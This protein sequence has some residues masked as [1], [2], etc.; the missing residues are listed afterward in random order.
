VRAAVEAGI[1]SSPSRPIGGDGCGGGIGYRTGDF[2]FYG[3]LPRNRH[4]AR[5]RPGSVLS[6]AGG[7]DL[8][9][10][11]SNACRHA[12]R[13]RGALS[14][15]AARRGPRDDEVHE[16]FV[17]GTV[18]GIAAA[19]REWLARVTLVWARSKPPPASSTRPANRRAHRERPR[20]GQRRKPS[21]AHS[22]RGPEAAPRDLRS[23]PYQKTKP[24]EPL[25]LL[26]NLDSPRS[27]PPSAKSAKGF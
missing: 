14:R 6:T 18:A 4:R 8:F 20:S 12:R 25:E 11:A 19:P 17:R 16:E 26:P 13:A 5:R 7:G 1:P 15:Q 24:S 27:E 23:G 22:L 3:F 2:R 21:P 9:E 10:S